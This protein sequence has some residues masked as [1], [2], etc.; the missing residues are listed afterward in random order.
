MEDEK[1]FLI[2]VILLTEKIKELAECRCSEL[3]TRS[4]FKADFVFNVV[5]LKMKVTEYLKEFRG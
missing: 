3:L 1:E 5:I 4:S 2:D